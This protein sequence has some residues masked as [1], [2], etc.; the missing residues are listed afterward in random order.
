MRMSSVVWFCV[1]MVCNTH[2]AACLIICIAGW[3]SVRPKGKRDGTR[4]LLN[5]GPSKKRPANGVVAIPRASTANPGTETWQAPEVVWSGA[6]DDPSG[7]RSH[8]RFM[9]TTDGKWHLAGAYAQYSATCDVTRIAHSKVHLTKWCF[10][11]VQSWF[12]SLLLRFTMQLLH[13]SQSK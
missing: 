4:H 2:L 10:S 3:A 11:G 8:Q 1:I 7:S 5:M 9:S 13:C 6:A 12:G